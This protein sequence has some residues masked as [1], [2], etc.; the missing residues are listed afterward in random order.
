MPTG[1]AAVAVV[2]A[3]QPFKWRHP[4]IV[5]SPGEKVLCLEARVR[6]R[7][8]SASQEPAAANSPGSRDALG[9]SWRKPKRS[10]QLSEKQLTQLHDTLGGAV[11]AAAPKVI[12]LHLDPTRSRDTRA[13]HNFAIS[14]DGQQVASN[15][16]LPTGIPRP[17]RGWFHSLTFVACAPS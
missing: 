4:Q 8:L 5:S 17:K 6:L 3:R 14:Y 2:S 7:I 9:V 11:V 13:L 10:N 15:P 1:A 12:R 16:R